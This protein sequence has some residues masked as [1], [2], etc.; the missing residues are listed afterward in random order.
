MN[1]QVR[2]GS[3]ILFQRELH[4]TEA[5]VDIELPAVEIE[6]CGSPRKLDL[7]IGISEGKTPMEAGVCPD[8]RRVGFGLERVVIRMVR[9]QQ[10]RLAAASQIFRRMLS[11]AREPTA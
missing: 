10:S 8:P 1:I 5:R 11:G 2:A 6:A 9:R 4:V 7:I 3:S